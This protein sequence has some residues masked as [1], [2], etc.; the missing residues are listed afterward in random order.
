[1]RD[2]LPHQ[3]TGLSYCL[4]V[5]DPAL[6]MQMRLGKTLLAIRYAQALE[7]REDCRRVL[8][9]APVTVL[10]AWRRELSLEEEVYLD[11]RVHPK[12]KWGDLLLQAWE[13]KHRVWTLANHE[14]IRSLPQLG[15]VPWNIAIVDESTVI[16]NPKS[17]ITKVY[18][19]TFRQAQHRM[20]LS[21]LVAPESYLD[22]FCQYQFLNGVFLGCHNYWDFRAQFFAP[23]GWKGYEYY[24]IPGAREKIQKH[25]QDRAFV[26][27]RQQA[28]IGSRKILSQRTV[29]MN[30]LQRDLYRTIV[31]K[32]AYQREDASWNETQWAPIV[33]LWLSRIA[34]GFDPEGK[35]LISDAKVKELLYLLSEDLRG[36]QLMIWFH[37]RAELEH[38][39]QTLSGKGFKLGCIHGG[40]LDKD[41]DK[42][43]DAFTSRKIQIILATQKSLRYGRDCSISDTAIYYSNEWSC[44]LR[45]QSEDRIINPLQKQPKLLI[46]L[47]TEETVDE[48]VSERVRDKAFNANYILTK[49]ID[50]I[51][52][53]L[54]RK[55]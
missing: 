50:K 31:K 12:S 24:P 52:R 11:L 30:T 23:G 34:G 19:S 53:S 55:R 4:S 28:G 5:S 36:E 27:T 14:A 15:L 41:R 43:L 10:G 42:V 26:L 35:T 8:V 40:V 44:E 22:L 39:R 6:I 29:E 13:S 46:D 20:I 17:K 49:H 38:V 21:G 2:L 9:T 18:T 54:I 51:S 48:D 47:V 37:F 1:M 32:A 7:D 3:K 25:L 33:Q 16:K 45:M